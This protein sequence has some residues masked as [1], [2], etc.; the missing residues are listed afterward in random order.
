MSSLCKLSQNGAG[1]EAIWGKEKRMEILNDVGFK[2]D[3]KIIITLLI[4]TSSMSWWDNS[5]QRQ[6][7]ILTEK[8]VGKPIKFENCRGV[9]T[10]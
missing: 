4:R 8:G 1:L 3:F 10:I 2:N 7:A 5:Y 9:E 6:E